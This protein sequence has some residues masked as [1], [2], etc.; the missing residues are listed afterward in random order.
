MEVFAHHN[1]VVRATSV[2][3]CYLQDFAPQL[4]LMALS[5]PLILN[6][7][8]IIVH[9]ILFPVYVHNALPRLLH[10]HVGEQEVFVA[11]YHPLLVVQEHFVM[12]L[13]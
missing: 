1:L 4:N 5:V 8:A 6:A 13:F 2:M 10:Q 3:D 9:L 12:A 11:R 7:Q